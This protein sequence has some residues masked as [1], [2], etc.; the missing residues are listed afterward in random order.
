MRL[1]N[2][3]VECYNTQDVTMLIFVDLQQTSS[4]IFVIHI[5]SKLENRTSCPVDYI[6]TYHYILNK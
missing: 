3:D 5:T 2:R 6:S 1:R 4:Y